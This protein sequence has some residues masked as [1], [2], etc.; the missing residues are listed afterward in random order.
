MEKG[1]G[2]PQA[3]GVNILVDYFL[4]P[5]IVLYALLLLL[6]RRLKTLLKRSKDGLRRS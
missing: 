5:D 2:V 1:G 4:F 3:G 6:L